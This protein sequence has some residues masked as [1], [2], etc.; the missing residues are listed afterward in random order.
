MSVE[1]NKGTIYSFT[2]YYEPEKAPPGFQGQ[3][4][5]VVGLVD[6]DSVGRIMAMI[7]D[8][9]WHS[10]IRNIGGE[11][12]RVNV[13]N[14]EIGMPVEKVFRK[15]TEDGKSG[16]IVYGYKFRPLLQEV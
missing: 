15:L 9:E 2:T 10:E 3:V 5:Y 4:P 6:T 11:E 12:R 8:L 7:T 16:I 13:P 14:I 1:I